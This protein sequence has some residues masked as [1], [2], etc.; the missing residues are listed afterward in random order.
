MS[1]SIGQ[2]PTLL[3]SATHVEI[4]SWIIDVWIENHSASDNNCNTMI[5]K[6]SK[7]LQA[8]TNNVGLT[9]SVGHTIPRFSVS[10]EQD[11]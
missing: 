7:S 3:L 6:P 10:I 11:N 9:F 8:M 4:L 2:N 1:S 5:Y